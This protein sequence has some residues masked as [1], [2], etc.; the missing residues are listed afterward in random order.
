MKNHCSLETCRR[1]SAC[2][3][4]TLFLKKLDDMGTTPLPTQLLLGLLCILPFNIRQRL[5]TLK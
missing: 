3:K 4:P 2:V 1:S 5:E